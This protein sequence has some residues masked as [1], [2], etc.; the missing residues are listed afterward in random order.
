M[1][2][3]LNSLWGDTDAEIEVSCPES[4]EFSRVLFL[5]WGRI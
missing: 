3:I 2:D 5:E 4:P 1:K